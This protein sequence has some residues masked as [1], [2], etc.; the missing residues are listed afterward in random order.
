VILEERAIA[1]GLPVAPQVVGD[2][3]V[4]VALEVAVVGIP[5]P[6]HR[7]EVE[8]LG[9]LAT[10]AAALP[11]ERGPAAARLPGQL[12]GGLETVVAVERHRPRQRGQ[13]LDVERQDEDLVPEDV[14][15]VGLA[16][17]AAGGDADVAAAGVR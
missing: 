15:A 10:V 2:R 5:S 6:R 1:G 16:V 3:R 11:G 17:E 8:L 14:A 12:S 4:D 7:V 9:G 13:A